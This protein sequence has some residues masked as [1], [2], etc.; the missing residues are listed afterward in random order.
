MQPSLL[1]I[2]CGVLVSQLSFAA[3]IVTDEVCVTGG[4][5]VTSNSD[6]TKP[7]APVFSKSCM[8][9]T[10]NGVTIGASSDAVSSN[11]GCLKALKDSNLFSGK[12]IMLPDEGDFFIKGNDGASNV[13]TK[14]GVFK[15][16]AK[17]SC[18]RDQS[19]TADDVIAGLAKQAQQESKVSQ[20]CRGLLG[21]KGAAAAA[22]SGSR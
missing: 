2:L 21:A 6:H 17:A 18:T 5:Y 12:I 16:N 8:D 22:S 20:A 15:I 19:L 3:T 4:G 11:K 10:Y 9:G 14:N 7:F 1:T 13:V